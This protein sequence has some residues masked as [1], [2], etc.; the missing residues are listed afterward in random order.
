MSKNLLHNLDYEIRQIERFG[1]I[2]RTAKKAIEEH[3]SKT[4][5]LKRQLPKFKII[6]SSELGNDWRATRHVYGKYADL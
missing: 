4:K 1:R 2:E 3:R 5:A 6:Q